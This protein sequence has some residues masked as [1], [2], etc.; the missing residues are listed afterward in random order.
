MKENLRFLYNKAQHL[1]DDKQW[2]D[3]ARNIVDKRAEQYS[4]TDMAVA[5]VYAALSP[6][7]DWD[8]MSTSVTA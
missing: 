3:G 8:K 7:K 1:E 5:G 4:L 6:Q 2:Y